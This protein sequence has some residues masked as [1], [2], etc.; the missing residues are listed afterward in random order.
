MREKMPLR[1]RSS[2]ED[3]PGT[4]VVSDEE[5]EGMNME[6]QL[7][8]GIAYDKNE[9]RISLLGLSDKPGTVAAI[10]APLAKANVNV[11]LIV[12]SVPRDGAKRDL[13]FTVPTAA[14]A[15]S[16]G[17]LTRAKAAQ[18]GRAKV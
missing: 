1:V 17:T 15:Q 2:F 3:R 11:D 5:L 6:R 13:T 18:I 7:I 16:V 10:F 9:A 8:T 4:M 14:L 12:Q